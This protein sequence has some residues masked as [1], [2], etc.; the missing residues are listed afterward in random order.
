M[1]NSANPSNNIPLEDVE[2]GHA[3]LYVPDKSDTTDQAH[4]KIVNALGVI[5]DTITPNIKIK[6]TL[7]VGKILINCERGIKTWVADELAKPV[8]N[9]LPNSETGVWIHYLTLGIERDFGRTWDKE[10]V[11][12]NGR[13]YNYKKQSSTQKK[14]SSGK[15]VITK[16]EKNDLLMKS[17]WSYWMPMVSAGKMSMEEGMKEFQQ[18]AEKI[19]ELEKLG[20]TLSEN[21]T[22]GVSDFNVDRSVID[23]WGGNWEALDILQKHKITILIPDIIENFFTSRDRPKTSIMNAA[24]GCKQLM[25][26]VYHKGKE[27]GYKSNMFASYETEAI[28]DRDDLWKQ[29][30]EFYKVISTGKHSGYEIK[31]IHIGKTKT[32]GKDKCLIVDGVDIKSSK[33]ILFVL[34]SADD[35]TTI[36]D[37]LWYNNEEVIKEMEF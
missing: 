12:L 29:V 19:Q 4:E 23:V 17:N 20:I 11:S 28:K 2:V 1:G 34:D 8:D 25:L 24:L 13:E 15:R 21:K 18:V 10:P 35:T 6:E 26:G 22:A 32:T 9:G 14:A 30:P 5:T 31:S 3:G 7:N 33:R 37:D 16:A 27:T 36:Y